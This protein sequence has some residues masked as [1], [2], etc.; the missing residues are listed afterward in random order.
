MPVNRIAVQLAF[1]LKFGQMTVKN[2]LSALNHFFTSFHLTQMPQ[3]VKQ[4]APV[5]LPVPPVRH[6]IH[7]ECL[8]NNYSLGK[9]SSTL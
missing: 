2:H 6:A 3:T 1:L 4:L 9:K 8:V 5:N 7:T